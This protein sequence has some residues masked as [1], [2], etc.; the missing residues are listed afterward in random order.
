M[1]E[2][3]Y[4]IASRFIAYVEACDLDSL[5]AMYAPDGVVN[6]NVLGLDQP[7]AETFETLKSMHQRAESLRYEVLEV[8]PTESGYVQRH[9]LHVVV[10][11]AEDSE[12]QNLVIPACL[13]VKLDQGGLITRVD[14][15]LDS[16][17]IAPLFQRQLSASK[18]ARQSKLHL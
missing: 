13:I 9:R 2:D 10:P 5:S 16:A 3:V 14:E 4:A 11:R 7:A 17:Q 6:I 15:Y 8:I 1:P 12:A 18:P